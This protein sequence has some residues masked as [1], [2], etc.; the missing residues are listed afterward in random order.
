MKNF[1]YK[2]IFV[3]LLTTPLTGYTQNTLGKADEIFR[4]V[5][6]ADGFIDKEL[7]QAF[8]SELAKYNKN[9]TERLTKWASANILSMQEYQQEL[10]ESALISYRN[11]KIVKTEGLISLE[12]KLPI[13]LKQ[14]LPFAPGSSEYLKNEAAINRRLATAM[15]NSKNLL[16]AASRHSEFRG[17]NG[18]IIPLDEDRI[19]HV[20]NNIKGSVY[21]FRKLLNKE[22]QE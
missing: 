12:T 4:T 13:T 6:S 14:S 21:R 18:E 22:W 7:H 8:W 3:F 17:V 19:I 5:I 9:E 11:K 15:D 20:M 1:I 10:W 2:L 16:F